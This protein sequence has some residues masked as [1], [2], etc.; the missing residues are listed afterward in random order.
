M[1]LNSLQTN[2]RNVEDDESVGSF[3]E[4]VDIDWVKREIKLFDG[5]LKM[6]SALELN[7]SPKLKKPKHQIHTK[8]S[9]ISNFFKLNSPS[10]VSTRLADSGFTY[11]SVTQPFQLALTIGKPQKSLY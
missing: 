9:K 7:S 5:R 11:P 10:S 6:E 3:K 2:H 8:R 4:I 1:R